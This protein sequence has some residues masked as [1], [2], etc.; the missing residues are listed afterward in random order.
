MQESFFYSEKSQVLPTI[1]YEWTKTFRFSC[2]VNRKGNVSLYDVVTE[3]SGV[4][5][6][7]LLY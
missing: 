5:V 2:I 4:D 6:N 3:F 7:V 1:N